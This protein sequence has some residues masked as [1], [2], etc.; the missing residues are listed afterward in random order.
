[1]FGDMQSQRRVKAVLLQI[2][3]SPA[4]ESAWPLAAGAILHSSRAWA[5]ALS[6][7]V[8]VVVLAEVGCGGAFVHEC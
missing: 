4:E 8:M 5:S 7:C 1:M 6:S 3:P 2:V